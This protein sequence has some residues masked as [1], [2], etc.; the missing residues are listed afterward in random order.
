MSVLKDI[1]IRTAFHEHLKKDPKVWFRDEVGFHGAIA[2]ILVVTPNDL[3][4]YE[5]KSDADTLSR[6]ASKL[7]ETKTKKGKTRMRYQ[8]G[9]VECYGKAAD[10]VTLVVGTKLLAES[11]TQIPE[12]WGVILAESDGVNITFKEVRDA[13]P[14]PEISWR[15]VF[16]LLW[17]DEV[18][19]LGERV[20]ASGILSKSKVNIGRIVEPMCPLP[21]LRKF[22]RECFP[23]RVWT[24][25]KKKSGRGRTRKRR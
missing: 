15:Y 18:L 5:I 16:E 12:W 17:R 9:Q 22:V 6:L 19:R 8:F 24:K 11:L 10:K 4:V 1:D 2:D 21:E 25:F 7:I 13:L 23:R 20:K 3:H 14:N